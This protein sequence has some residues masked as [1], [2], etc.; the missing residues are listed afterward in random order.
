[1]LFVSGLAILLSIAPIASDLLQTGESTAEASPL[2]RAWLGIELS[3]APGGGV[4]AKHVIRSSPAMKAGIKDGDVLLTIDKTAV[5][6]PADVI[7]HVAEMGPDKTLTIHLRRAGAE[8][9][10]PVK[11]A[12]HP[13]DMEVLRLDKIGTFAPGWKSGKA[14]GGAPDD[15]GKLKGRIVLVD[16][17]ASWCGACREATPS[18]VALSDKYGA[19]GATIIGVTSDS[20]DVAAKGAKKFG[21]NYGVVADVSDDTLMEYSVRA[22]P[23]MYLVDRKG[24][25]REVFVGFPGQAPI[26]EAMKK[27]LADTTP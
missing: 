4:L 21:I 9:D 18:L 11:L 15:I 14:S 27:L 1:M 20:A 12:E 3:K 26:E 6:A 13:G 19:Q 25:I 7:S 5:E 8:Q 24:V 10:V 17:W 16:F 22:L 2:R 23:S